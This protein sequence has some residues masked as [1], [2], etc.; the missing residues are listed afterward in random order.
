VASAARNPVVGL[1]ACGTAGESAGGVT[2]RARE[3]GGQFA[4]LLLPA[5]GAAGDAGIWA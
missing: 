2:T 4:F 5:L 1:R 3:R